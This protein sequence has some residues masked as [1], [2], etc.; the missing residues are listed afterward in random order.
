MCKSEKTHPAD[1]AREKAS[2]VVG[3]GK[4]E[5]KDFGPCKWRH[6]LGRECKP[7][8]TGKDIPRRG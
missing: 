7:R 5:T 3:A 2:A 6:P 8:Q 4:N 1:L